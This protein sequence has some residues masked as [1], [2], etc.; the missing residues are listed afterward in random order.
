M[1]KQV[2]SGYM[3][4][5]SSLLSF[6]NPLNIQNAL[7]F[8]NW[9]VEG[10]GFLHLHKHTSFSPRRSR[11]GFLSHTFEKNPLVLLLL[12][13]LVCWYRIFMPNLGCLGTQNSCFILTVAELTGMGHSTRWEGKSKAQWCIVSECL[14]P[15]LFVEV[16]S[17]M[18]DFLVN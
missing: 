18:Q 2:T 3:T 6:S 16:S 8:N 10:W 15:Y 9:N 14:S 7:T 5:V 1:I 17:R 12:L 11:E 13:W 4:A